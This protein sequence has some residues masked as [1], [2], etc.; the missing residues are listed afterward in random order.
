MNC[1]TLHFKDILEILTPTNNGLFSPHVGNKEKSHWVECKV[2]SI[3][4]CCEE[5][6]VIIN[7]TDTGEGQPWSLTFTLFL[8][9]VVF[10]CIMLLM[11]VL[12]VCRPV[13]QS[14]RCQRGEPETEVWEP[15]SGSVHWEPHV[16]LQCL[17]D[18]W[19]Q[20]QTKVRRTSE[21]LDLIIPLTFH[22]LNPKHPGRLD[23]N[24]RHHGPFYTAWV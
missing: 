11:T 9:C 18:H 5:E 23:S 16:C 12:C 13:C 14:G 7:M 10:C 3:I 6:E 2:M 15:G 4:M 20:E 19:H 17:P 24:S 1:N 8:F 22:N 21:S